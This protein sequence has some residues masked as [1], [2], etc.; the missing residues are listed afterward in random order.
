MLTPYL[1]A[2]SK[3]WLGFYQQFLCFGVWICAIPNADLSTA[4]SSHLGET[5]YT[6]LL[7]I[8]KTSRKWP[9]L[10]TKKLATVYLIVFFALQCCVFKLL[11]HTLRIYMFLR[12]YK[13]CKWGIYKALIFYIVP[14]KGQSYFP[15]I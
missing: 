9:C 3:S 6:F 2:F 8:E 13:S 12:I 15:W 11:M 14:L 4:L 5:T 7:I 1:Y 10:K